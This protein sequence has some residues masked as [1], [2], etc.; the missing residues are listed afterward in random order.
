MADR[1]VGGCCDLGERQPELAPPPRNR[2]P[3]TFTIEARVGF[4]AVAYDRRGQDP[5]RSTDSSETTSA[6]W[7]CCDE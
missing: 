4:W 6:A 5:E 7:P 3:R 2:R 1:D